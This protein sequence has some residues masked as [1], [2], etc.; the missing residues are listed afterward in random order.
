M[1]VCLCVRV[2]VYRRGGRGCIT[3]RLYVHEMEVLA[4]AV[5]DEREKP[6]LSLSIPGGIPWVPREYPVSNP[7]NAFASETSNACRVAKQMP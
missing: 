2:C 4:K 1:C 6:R 7:C 3:R 5:V